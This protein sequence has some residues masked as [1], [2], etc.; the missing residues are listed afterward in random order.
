MCHI[1][2][3]RLFHTF[4][5]AS[6]RGLPSLKSHNFSWW[7]LTPPLHNRWVL[8]RLCNQRLLRYLRLRFSRNGGHLRFQLAFY[9]GSLGNTAYYF[10]VALSSRSHA[11]DFLKRIAFGCSDFPHKFLCAIILLL[12]FWII[13]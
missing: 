2:S 12:S 5:L 13:I 11:L 6:F 3:R 9:Q 7:A 10:S 4:K 8:V 1:A